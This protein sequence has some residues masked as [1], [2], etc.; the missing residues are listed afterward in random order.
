MSS[1][2]IEGAAG[3]RVARLSAWHLARSASVSAILRAAMVDR[4]S[5]GPGPLEYGS[6]ARACRVRCTLIPS[7]G[8]GETPGLLAPT[9]TCGLWQ[10]ACR[11]VG[12]R[13]GSAVG[14]TFTGPGVQEL[15]HSATVAICSGA[16]V[17]RL[18]R[19]VPPFPTISEVWLSLLE[20]YGL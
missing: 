6:G 16:P 17:E 18:R 7:M 15:L 12:G 10:S 11:R 3:G 5:A 8:N 20:A 1:R 19:P 13:R 9:V 14:A 4:R 2:L